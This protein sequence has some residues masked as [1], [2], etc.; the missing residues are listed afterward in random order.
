MG[1]SRLDKIRADK[2][3]ELLYKSGNAGV[4]KATVTITFENISEKTAAILGIK[5]YEDI[6]LSR[7]ISKDGKTK[8]RLEWS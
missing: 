5:N 7:S 2:Y 3:L 8:Y 1:I 4:T 6:S